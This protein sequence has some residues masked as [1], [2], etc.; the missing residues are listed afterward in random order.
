M[1]VKYEIRKGDTSPCKLVSIIPTKFG[2][3]AVNFVAEGTHTY[4]KDV[5]DRLERVQAMMGS[6][7]RQ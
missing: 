2:G 5:K 1:T 6:G 4:C 3:D 7:V